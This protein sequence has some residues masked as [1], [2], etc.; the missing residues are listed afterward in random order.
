MCTDAP[1]L[2]IPTPNRLIDKVSFLR[3]MSYFFHFVHSLCTTLCLQWEPEIVAV[4]LMYLASRLTK[5]EPSDWI[6]RENNKSKWWE[7]FLEGMSMELM[8]GTLQNSIY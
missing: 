2:P 7:D 4:S 6:N 8:E 3:V 1:K 5:F